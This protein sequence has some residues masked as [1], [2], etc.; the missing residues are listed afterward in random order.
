MLFVMTLTNFLTGKIFILCTSVF[1]K[2]DL[3]KS[4]FLFAAVLSRKQKLGKGVKMR[5]HTIGIAVLLFNCLA[6]ANAAVSAESSPRLECAILV[7]E[8]IQALA[9]KPFSGA[10]AVSVSLAI[11]GKNLNCEGIA[12]TTREGEESSYVFVTYADGDVTARSI[13]GPAGD[14]ISLNTLSGDGSSLIQSECICQ[15]K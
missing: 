15:I 6:L 13:N 5:K 12:M 9:A 3:R 10:E 14:T 11:G 2:E 1:D 7:D 4:V 8:R